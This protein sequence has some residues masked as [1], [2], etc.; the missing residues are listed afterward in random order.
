MALESL[1]GVPL[2]NLKSLETLV[3]GVTGRG[4]FHLLG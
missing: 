3:T 2:Q 4:V 1:V